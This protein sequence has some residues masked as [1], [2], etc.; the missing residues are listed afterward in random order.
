MLRLIEMSEG[1]NQRKGRGLSLSYATNMCRRLDHLH[2]YKLTYLESSDQ[3]VITTDEADELLSLLENDKIKKRS[4]DTYAPGAKRKFK[5]ALVKYQE[6]RYDKEEL[7]GEWDPPTT[8]SD[9]RS[10]QTTARTFTLEELGR[11]FEAAEEYKSLP[12]YYDVS[13]EQ[14]E[15]IDALVAQRLSIPK[16]EVT[17]KDR[18]RA[19]FSTKYRALI[20]VSY[21]AGLT[22]KEIQRATKDWF[23]PKR[24]LLKIPTEHATKEREKETVALSDAACEALSK[25]IQERRHLKQYD[26]R[27]ELW[28][29]REGNPYE[30]GPLCHLLRQVCEEASISGDD[31]DPIRW[32]SLRRTMA[33]HTKTQGGLE[34]ASDQLRHSRLDTTQEE[35][36][37]TVPG[38]RRSTLNETHEKAQQAAEDPDY[39]PYGKESPR[40]VMDT[41]RPTTS[42]SDEAVTPVDDQKVHVD[43][44][45]PDT[46]EAKADITEELWSDD[47]D[48]ESPPD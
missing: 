21:D 29:N 1:K 30:S 10:S 40:R 19:D 48:E 41:H 6:W 43:A 33:E 18:Q 25:W 32:Y 39:D 26:G 8:F 38:K 12:S 24:Q 16:E 31:N 2:R 9:D 42:G 37:N 20:L 35:Y 17:V 5:D 13:E 23:Y 44:V 22:P 46:A 14:Q 47:D 15:K 7:Q 4:G 27:T 28:L 3:T 11:L 36:P 45:I 34:E